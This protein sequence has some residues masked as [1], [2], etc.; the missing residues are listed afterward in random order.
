MARQSTPGFFVMLNG[1]PIS[2]KSIRQYC[3]ALSFAEDDYIAM[4]TTAKELCCIR[5]ICWKIWFQ[6][7]FGQNWIIPNIPMHIDNTAALSIADQ[8]GFSA[9]T[10][11]ISIKYHH[12]RNLRASRVLS[13]HYV[14]T[15]EQVA[16]IFTKRVDKRSLQYLRG[17]LW[18]ESRQ[19][20][21]YLSM[22]RTNSSSDRPYV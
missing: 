9:R 11:H 3:V 15:S 2:K 1:S 16:A 22:E 8:E 21:E 4:S 13:L 20:F 6:R 14:R 17:V 7:P 10:K 12:I 19:G 18:V 5:R